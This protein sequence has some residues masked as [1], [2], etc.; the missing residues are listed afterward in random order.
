MSTPTRLHRLDGHVFDALARGGGG[1]QAVS[2][3]RTVQLSKHLLL[4]RAVLDL[5]LET[6]PEQAR[7]AALEASFEA[8]VTAD[9]RDR[10]G[11]RAVLAYPHVGAWAT[12]CLRRLAQPADHS[13]LPLWADLA[14]LGAV[15]AAAA[16]CAGADVE[17]LVPVLGGT[18][19]LPSLGQVLLRELDGSGVARLAV[20]GGTVE[21]LGRPDARL[22]C[23]EPTASSPAWRRV[24]A[25]KLR[26]DGLTLRVDLDD[27]DPYRD[28]HGL[29]AAA[30][31]DDADAEVWRQQLAHAWQLLV[32]RHN[33]RAEAMAEGMR[34]IVPLAD[35]DP[36]ARGSSATSRHAFGAVTLTRPAT[37]LALGLALVHEFQHTKLSALMDLVPLTTGP[38]DGRGGGRAGEEHRRRFYAPWRDDP[39]PV[40]GLLHG[41]YAFLGVTDFWRY[42]RAGP[43]SAGDRMAGFHFAVARQQVATACRSLAESGELTPAGRRFVAAMAATL[44]EWLAEPVSGDLTQLA[45]DA[46]AEHLAR[47]RLRNVV[48]DENT[49]GRLAECAAATGAAWPGGQGPPQLV[50]VT[51]ATERLRLDGPRFT[52][53]PLWR[54]AMLARVGDPAAFRRAVAEPAGWADRWPAATTADLALAASEYA[55]AARLLRAQVEGGDCSDE[56]W[57]ALAVATRRQVPP[58]L[59]SAGYSGSVL[60]LAERPEMARALYRRLAAAMP[61]SSA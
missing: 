13:G 23:R 12:H 48:L 45:E 19:T 30:R 1:P 59:T 5:A 16:T 34:V 35:G 27:V 52:G 50:A 57:A 28:C 53:M 21:V 10:A 33:S 4:V 24:R 14:H 37:A 49:V 46:N 17:V 7:R 25:L 58:G 42:E 36:L 18:V 3:L 2:I 29:G 44:G 40:D 15:A 20:R 51:V 22:D 43:D 32:R 61:A 55:E 41:A 56:V 11:T 9:D 26:C 54:Q 39:R 31:L 38:L 8:L 6:A 47:W 60:L